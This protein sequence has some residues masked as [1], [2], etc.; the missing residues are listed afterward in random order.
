MKRTSIL[1]IIVTL[2][3]IGGAAIPVLGQ[4]AEQ[5]IARMEANQEH[6]TSISTGR[7]VITDRFGERTK[8]FR[9]VASDDRTLIE[10]TNPEEA[11]QKILQLA[12]DIYLFFP[13]ADEL[14]HLQGAARRDS[15]MGS[16]FS[17]ED[18][19]GEG[20]LLDDYDATLEG[21]EMVDGH[22]TLK[23]H[24]TARTRDVVYPQQDVWVDTDLYVFRKVVLY[25]QR[26][27]AL[28][29]MQI[30]RFQEFGDKTVPVHFEMRDLMKRNSVTEF[31]VTD[32]QIGVAIDEAQFSLEDLTF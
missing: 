26:G 8:T 30:D 4:T 1:K 16:D 9:S 32:L 24:L 20:G 18:L 29:E 27:R 13:E 11:G 15:V 22:Q 2:A 23:L 12:G 7:M 28:K 25:S 3:W 10:F 19:A 31:T 21:T 5:I 17:Y 14:I 6:A